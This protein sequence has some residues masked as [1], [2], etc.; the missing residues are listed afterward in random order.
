MAVVN[1]AVK[2][3][4][5]GLSRKTHWAESREMHV[6][7]LESPPSQGVP[8]RMFSFLQLSNR[9]THQDPQWKQLRGHSLL[10]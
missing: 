10:P 4:T 5:I 1:V 6:Q 8:G 3:Y 7:H 9:G 2:R